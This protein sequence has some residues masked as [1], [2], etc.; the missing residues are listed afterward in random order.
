MTSVIFTSDHGVLIDYTNDFGGADGQVFNPRG[1]T[2]DGTNNPIPHPKGTNLTA[3]VTF[4]VRPAGVE[5]D[6]TGQ[7]F[8]A[9]F[10][11][12]TNDLTSSGADQ[13]QSLTADDPLL[14]QVVVYNSSIDWSIMAGGV[15]FPMTSSG[16]HK[17]YVTWDQPGEDPTL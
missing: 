14:D 9:Y 13:T 12:H 10:T 15:E 1:W 5:F 4:C 17:V 7:G 16:P 8:F 2:A 6:L 11:F 3:N